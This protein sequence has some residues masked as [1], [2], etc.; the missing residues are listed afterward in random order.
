MNKNKLTDLEEQPRE[1][2]ECIMICRICSLELDCIDVTNRMN[3]EDM[4]FICAN[5]E[6]LFAKKEE[7]ILAN[8]IFTA[9]SEDEVVEAVKMERDEK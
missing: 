2:N 6:L 8:S 9:V 1:K 5:C 3:E 4:T 7:E